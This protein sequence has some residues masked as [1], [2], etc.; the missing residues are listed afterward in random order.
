MGKEKTPEEF[1]NKYKKGDLIDRDKQLENLKP[2]FELFLDG[3]IT[4]ITPE[5][6]RWHI[7]KSLLKSYFDD[8]IE[9]FN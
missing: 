7:L 9:S 2:V 5:K 4:K 3:T 8:L 1:W 6:Y